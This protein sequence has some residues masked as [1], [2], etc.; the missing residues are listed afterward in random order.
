MS[1]RLQSHPSTAGI[2]PTALGLEPHEGAPAP[3]PPATTSP[4]S[5]AFQP[6]AAARWLDDGF[7]A[8]ASPGAVSTD[9]TL[10][11]HPVTMDGELFALSIKGTLGQATA[12]GAVAR[13]E[14]R[15]PESGES[16]SGELLSFKAS[17]GSMNPDGSVGRNVSL[18]ATLYAAEATVTRAGNSVTLGLGAGAGAE[19]SYGTRD[20][21]K[22]NRPEYCA[23]VSATWLTVGF[24][25]EN[26]S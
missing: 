8:E 24:C 25:L 22:D 20:I 23:R 11:G 14:V 18:G 10:F 1:N 9:Q 6:R 17:S 4:G 3:S 5:D 21:D 2:C 16:F 15:S 19:F 26:P 13:V 12:Q 7:E